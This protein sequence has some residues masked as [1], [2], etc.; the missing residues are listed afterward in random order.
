[1]MRIHKT[2]PNKNNTEQVQ[3]TQLSGACMHSHYQLFHNVTVHVDDPF[4]LVLVKDVAYDFQLVCQLFYW[5]DILDSLKPLFFP[6]D[7]AL[8]QFLVIIGGFFCQIS[9]SS[10]Y[11]LLHCF[12]ATSHH[13][14]LELKAPENM[15]MVG[16]WDVIDGSLAVCFWSGVFRLFFLLCERLTEVACRWTII[17]I[18]L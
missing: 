12:L 16:L 9:I 13:S 8:H 5:I 4:C 3:Q 17:C 10:L 6:G 1:M 11:S 14:C 2:S 18:H 7:S 15:G